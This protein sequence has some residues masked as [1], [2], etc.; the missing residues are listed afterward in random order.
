VGCTPDLVL[1]KYGLAVFVDGDYWHSC[2]VHTSKRTFNGPNS[3]AWAEKFQ[4]NT[5][6]DRRSTAIAEDHGWTVV[7]VWEC[8]IRADVASCADQVLAGISPSPVPD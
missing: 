7:R 3:R 2:P 4:R 8:A 5:E 1:P 6:R